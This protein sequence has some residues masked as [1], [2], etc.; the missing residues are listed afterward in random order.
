MG[1]ASSP[2][3]PELLALLRQVKATPADET[4]RL[5]LADWLDENGDAADRA[6]AALIRTDAEWRGRPAP[7][8]DETQQRLREQMQALERAYGSEWL[9]PLRQSGVTCNFFRGLVHVETNV[10]V[11]AAW[12]NRAWPQTEAWAWVERARLVNGAP[13]DV[14]K[15]A[16]SPAP[17]SLAILELVVTR[18]DP[19]AA[20]ALARSPHLANLS[21]LEVSHLGAEGS[22]ALTRSPHLG[23]L[24]ALGLLGSGLRDEHVVELLEAP[25][26]GQLTDLGLTGNSFTVESVRALASCPRLANL[27]KLRLG[28]NNGLREG[29][30]AALAPSPY[31]VNLEDLEWNGGF[32]READAEAILASPHL[33]KLRCLYGVS[34]YFLS[35]LLRERMRERFRFG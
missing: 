7:G 26:L 9:G 25:C 35:E 6:R 11:V 15:L 21:R 34:C 27:R 19:A 16:E 1:H 17:G 2:P 3:R 14:T 31:L 10:G 28:H 29:A 24:T 22:V 4:L 30:L 33:R 20:A 13:A 32:L 12:R 23:R 18:A 5:V 8:H